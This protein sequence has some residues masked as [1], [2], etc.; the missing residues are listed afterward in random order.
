M[1]RTR[2]KAVIIRFWGLV[3]SLALLM[4]VSSTAVACASWY[5]QPKV[6]QGMEKYVRR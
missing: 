5:H 6:P 2:L 4:G 1:R 3:A